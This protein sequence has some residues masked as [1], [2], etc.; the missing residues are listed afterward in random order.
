MLTPHST[1]FSH[2]FLSR[3]LANA[4]SLSHVFHVPLASAR[5]LPAG[6]VIVL[7]PSLQLLLCS[8]P[9]WGA[10]RPVEGQ[11]R[12]GGARYAMGVSLA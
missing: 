5:D 10:C 6:H 2:S 11:R 8:L 3:K 7:I 9:P 12:S 4:F 1:P